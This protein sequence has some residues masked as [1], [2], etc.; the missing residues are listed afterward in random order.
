MVLLIGG[1]LN[2]VLEAT[3]LNKDEPRALKK[4]AGKNVTQ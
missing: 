3:K 1:E 2:A 4:A